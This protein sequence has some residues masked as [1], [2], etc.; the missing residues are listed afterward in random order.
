[1]WFVSILGKFKGIE[2]LVT[3]RILLEDLV[4]KG[5]W[6]LIKR[7]DDHIKIL[8]TPKRENLGV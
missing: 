2:K 6:E 1:M 3:S 7:K 5:L 4:D 8:V